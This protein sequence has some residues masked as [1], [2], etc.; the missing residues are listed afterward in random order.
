MQAVRGHCR[1]Q[2]QGRFWSCHAFYLL[3]AGGVL[4]LYWQVQGLP[5]LHRS[6]SKGIKVSVVLCKP[7]LFSV[8]R[9]TSLLLARQF[10]AS[11]TQVLNILPFLAQI[12]L[13]LCSLGWAMTQSLSFRGFG[14]QVASQ[15]ANAEQVQ[16]F[17]YS[18]IHTWLWTCLV[19][20]LQHVAVQTA[21]DRPWDARGTDAIRPRTL[22]WAVSPQKGC[23]FPFCTNM[24]CGLVTVLILEKEEGITLGWEMKPSHWMR[25]IISPRFHSSFVLIRKKYSLGTFLKTQYHFGISMNTSKELLHSNHFLFQNH[26]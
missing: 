4:R 10:P 2:C 18:A 24:P 17:C 1:A 26:R 9:T 13:Q 5:I 3:T 19:L 11:H 16:E 25:C 20:G 8:S 22:G 21:Q 14:F 7:S 15:F 12:C 6:I 23:L